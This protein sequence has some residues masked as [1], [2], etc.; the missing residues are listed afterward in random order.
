MRM[1]RRA[2]R[3]DD[4]RM[5]TEVGWRGGGRRKDFPRTFPI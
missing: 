3:E 1:K 2:K 5:R 4:V